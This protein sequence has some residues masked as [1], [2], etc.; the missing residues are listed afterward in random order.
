M[1]CWKCGNNRNLPEKPGRLDVCPKCHSFL[2]CCNNCKFLL[3]GAHNDCRESQAEFVQ[4][5]ANA[6]YC[7]YFSL[8]K[9][10][11]PV[12]EKKKKRLSREEAEKKW[13]E[14]LKKK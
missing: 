2:H 5:K 10:D 7:G 1:I 11:A 9:T 14:M 4:D 12:E 3:K 6:N 13:Q 8:K